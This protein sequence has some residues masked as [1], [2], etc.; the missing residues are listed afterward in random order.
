MALVDRIRPPAS[1]REARADTLV[2]QLVAELGLPGGRRGVLRAGSAVLVGLA[3]LDVLV[4]VDGPDRVDD[5][6]RQVAVARALATAGVPAIALAVTDDQPVA[7]DAGVLTL[8]GYVEPVADRATP[9]QVGHLA[10]QLHDALRPAAPAVGAGTAGPTAG[11]GTAGPTAG[12]GTAGPTAGAGTA[13]GVPELDPLAAVDRQL[14]AAARL[15]ATS[16]AELAALRAGIAAARVAWT[17]VGPADPLGRS[18]VHGDLHADNVVVGADGPVLADLEVSGWGPP[19]Y[20]LVPQLVAV[21]RYGADAAGYDRFSAAYGFDV[22][23]WSGASA[24][25][26]TYELWVTAWAVA[27]RTIS[28][29][30]EDEARRRLRGWL[31]GP[32]AGPGAGGSWQLL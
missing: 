9:D 24:L 5:A 18:L 1:D 30:H 11:A 13:P 15:G 17:E 8:W 19:S 2:Q 26:R 7:A 4:R 21:E 12:A 28:P 29:E 27:S 14:E 6:H 25:A 3:D 32:D 22:R 10:R 16:D 31:E 20:D 23:T